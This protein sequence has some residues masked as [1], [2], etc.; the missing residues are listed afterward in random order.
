[1]CCHHTKLAVG[2]ELYQVSDLGL[3]I[4]LLL[5]RFLVG[6]R[7]LVAG[8]GVG[9]RHYKSCA[10]RPVEYVGFRCRV[11][12][13]V[14]LNW[15]C[16]DVSQTGHQLEILKQLSDDLYLFEHQH[17]YNVALNCISGCHFIIDIAEKVLKRDQDVMTSKNAC[18]AVSIRDDTA[19]AQT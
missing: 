3:E 5:V 19:I 13:F 4:G 6:I 9:E 11:V 10:G 17:A 14:M 8:V 15:E 18:S 16:K 2:H 1:M 7:R 12:Y